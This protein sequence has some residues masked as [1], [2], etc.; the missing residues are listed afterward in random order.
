MTKINKIVAAYFSATGTTKKAVEEMAAAAAGKL[1]LPCEIRSFTLPEGRKE[2]LVFAADE[3]V[4]LGTPVYA[5]RVPNVLLKYLKTMVGNGALGVPVAVYGNRNYDDALV[6]LRDLMETAG[7]HTI[8]GAAF[9]GEHSFSTI[10]GAGRPDQEDLAE[11]KGF[12]E[13][14]AAKVQSG[15]LNEGPVAVKGNVPYR[16]YYVPKMQ[17][18]SNKNII[19]VF[20]KVD[21]DKCNNCQICVQLCPLG[22][23]NSEDVATYS[24]ICIKCGACVKGCPQGARYYDDP[25]YEY[26]KTNLE[27]NFMR[28]AKPEMFL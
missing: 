9:I 7:L 20:P 2:P 1:G 16:P 23:I 22:S 12:G 4:F 21:K 6:E 11:A 24:G 28:R 18:G 26:H 17:D 14:V 8:A 19:K 13:N 5:G 10:L 3:L 15:K 25:V 27:E